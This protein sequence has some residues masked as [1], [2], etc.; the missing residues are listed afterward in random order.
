[1]KDKVRNHFEEISGEYDRWKE[2]SAY[3]YQLLA[4]IYRE[5][6]PEGANVLEIGCGTGTIL[7]TLKP[8]RGVGVDISPGMISI[9]AA[10]FPHLTFLVADAEV[11]SPQENFDYVIVPDVVEHLSEVGAMFRSVRR[12]CH[13]ES[14]VIITCVNPLWAPVLHLA[15]RLGMKMPEGEHRWL[16]SE[17]LR[18]TAGEAGFVLVEFHGRIL[19]PKKIPILA[20]YLNLAAERFTFLRQVCLIQVLVFSPGLS[21]AVQS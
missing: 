15:E 16:P 21:P 19:C 5:Y 7:S 17:G 4:G 6:V 18:K 9:A 2:K 14:R 11:F 12:G 3:Y 13:E 1:L 10:K 8:S 20:H